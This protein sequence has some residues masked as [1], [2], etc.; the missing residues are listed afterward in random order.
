MAGAT[1]AAAASTASG[2]AAGGAGGTVRARCGEDRELDA[3]SLA[4][5][6]G[7]GDLLLLVDHDLLETGV[8]VVADVF[9]NRHFQVLVPLEVLRKLFHSQFRLSK[10]TL[11]DR[12][13]Q[14][15][16][17]VA[18]NGHPQMWFRGVPQLY[19]A[20]RLMMNLKTRFQ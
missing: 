4:G 12:G 14:V 11:Q 10:D 8:A 18:G 2:K 19:M 16:A 9:V 17:I 13:R 15:K 5:T 3:G 7:A 6:L 1:A 20:S